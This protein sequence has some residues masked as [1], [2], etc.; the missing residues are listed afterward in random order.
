[1]VQH[2]ILQLELI[3][4]YLFIMTVSYLQTTV[5]ALQMTINDLKMTFNDLQMTLRL[6]IMVPSDRARQ[7]LQKWSNINFSN[8][9]YSPAIYQKPAL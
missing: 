1:M 8:S 9:H 6:K 5:N 3:S 7:M 4:C 2:S